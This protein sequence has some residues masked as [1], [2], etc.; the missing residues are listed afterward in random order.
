V[1]YHIMQ[2]GISCRLP[3]TPR[4]KYIFHL[5]ITRPD[6]PKAPRS[7]A[8]HYF[9]EHPD[10]MSEGGDP[11]ATPFTPYSAYGVTSPPPSAIRTLE[12]LSPDAL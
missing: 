9:D 7:H 3:R 2:S 5:A 4:S 11:L 1:A 8:R 6:G 10:T 12:D